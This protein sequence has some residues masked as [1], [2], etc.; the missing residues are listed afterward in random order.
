[1]GCYRTYAVYRDGRKICVGTSAE[2]A[3]CLGIAVNTFY[4]YATTDG[5]APFGV[6]IVRNDDRKDLVIDGRRPPCVGCKQDGDC[7]F[8]CVAYRKWFARRWQEVRAV[9]RKALIKRKVQNDENGTLC[10]LRA[11]H[12][13][14]SEGRACGYEQQEG[15]VPVLRAKNLVEHVRRG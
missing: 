5:A 2:C 6:E 14:G 3:E 10:S 4:R 15:Q 9:W 12:G 11:A 8:L 1:M 7:A 13:D